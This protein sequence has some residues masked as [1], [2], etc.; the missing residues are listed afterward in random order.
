MSYILDALRKA[1]AERERGHVPSIHAQPVLPG[2]APASA[3][4]SPS[5][6]IW[7]GL[8][9]LLL[10]AVIGLTWWFLS[11]A[12]QRNAVVPTAAT[13]AATP[14]PPVSAAPA[15]AAA[16]A[17]TAPPAAAEPAPAPAATKPAPT[18]KP[19]SAATPQAGVGKSPASAAPTRSEVA[20]HSA[21]AA[22]GANEPHAGKIYA[23]SE[24]PDAIRSQLPQV[25]VGGSVYSPVRADRMLIV[26]GQVLHEGDRITPDVVLEQVRVKGA[27]LAFRGYRYLISF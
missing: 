5:V 26:N 19:K 22:T 17:P 6:A 13:P 3:A 18:P 4:R 8:G 20:P 24:L 12:A 21:P 10:A 7:I 25:N 16:P 15:V 27:V 14:M 11:S 9:A 1:E 2:S 23:V